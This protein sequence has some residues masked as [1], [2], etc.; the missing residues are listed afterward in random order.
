MQT[1]FS[2]FQTLDK[3]ATGTVINILYE[4][5]KK[6]YQEKYQNLFMDGEK[7]K[8]VYVMDWLLLCNYLKNC[9]TCIH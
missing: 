5:R 1:I 4:G 9:F 7:L 3:I 8:R 6:E 2:S